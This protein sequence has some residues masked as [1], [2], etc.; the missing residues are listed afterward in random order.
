MS[1]VEIL[2]K[3]NHMLPKG[4]TYESA[5]HFLYGFKISKNT[6][7]DP[8]WIPASEEDYRRSES[9]RLNIAPDAVPLPFECRMY[10]PG[11][12]SAGCSTGFCTSYQDGEG[13][14][15]CACS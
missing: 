8:I 14:Y 12:C 3:E 5:V 11:S 9:K 7:G 13:H 4:L 1:T 10:S 6:S 2:D 15:Y